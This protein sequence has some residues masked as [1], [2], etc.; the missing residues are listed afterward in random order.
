ME[1]RSPE[2]KMLSKRRQEENENAYTG[3]GHNDQ[4]NVALVKNVESGRNAEA[5]DEDKL[6]GD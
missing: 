3:I 1:M 4:E 5:N 6:S 2:E